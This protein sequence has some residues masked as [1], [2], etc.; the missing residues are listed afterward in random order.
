[1]A[2]GG[3][4]R[5]TGSGS[6]PFNFG[7]DDVLCSYDDLRS[8]DGPNVGRADSDKDFREGRA[9]KQLVNIYSQPE[10]SCNP[11]VIAAV[12]KCMKKYAD[13]L[14][15]YLEGISGRLSQLE[16]Y[17]HNL[18]RSIADYRSDISHNQ[19]EVDLKFRSLEKHL[20]EVHRSV[21]ILR[22][23]QE[24][25]DAQKE[26]ARLQLSQ[27]E[28]HASSATTSLSEPKKHEDVPETAPNLQ[29]A[30]A[31][32]H[33]PTQQTP[34]PSRAEQSHKVLPIQQPTSSPYILNQASSFYQPPQPPPQPQSQPPPQTELP[35]Y[36]QQQP[37][38]QAS[39]YPQYQQQWHQP[40]SQLPQQVQPQ[41]PQPQQSP[42]QAP[43]R[44]QTPP[45]YPSYS[46]QPPNPLPETFQASMPMQSRYS[47][48][49]PYGGYGGPQQQQQLSMSRQSH[50]LPPQIAKGG[51][52][53]GGGP[54]PV[55][56]YGGSMGTYGG[57]AGS[58]MG[59]PYAE[60]A[61]KAV[62]MGYG[63]EQVLMAIQRMEESGERVDFNALLDRLN[64]SGGGVAQRGWSG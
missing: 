34:L 45:I 13:N 60:L 37:S 19:D 16:V 56:R 25:A 8:Q 32:P 38:L 42:P 17:C 10:E 57:V 9:G 41:P 61:E 44:P 12:E 6:K 46:H 2:S 50:P 49:I 29:L 15:R 4:F 51:Y 18:E 64:M 58:H 20:Q 53:G 52:A 5:R 35:T 26:L 1:M 55:M 28:T 43:I 23:K 54:T 36:A 30:L 62:S 48:A 39:Q 24:L 3:S 14:M 59:Y 21:Q 47:G 31:L 22:D 27:K 7:S 33:Q 11:D 40:P 63:R